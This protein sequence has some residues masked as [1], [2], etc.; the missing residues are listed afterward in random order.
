VYR[1]PFCSSTAVNRRSP[2]AAVTST[3]TGV[4]APMTFT[5]GSIVI[6]GVAES[7]ASTTAAATN[8]ATTIAM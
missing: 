5:G 4:L 1:A 6:A 7:A 3:F 8:N 2:Y